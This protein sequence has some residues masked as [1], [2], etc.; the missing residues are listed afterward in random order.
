MQRI[1]LGK[2]HFTAIGT[3]KQ[4]TQSLRMAPGACCFR[5]EDSICLGG[6]KE[7]IYCVVVGVISPLIFVCGA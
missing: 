7:A 4:S 3:V 2:R 5:R 6:Q 1:L